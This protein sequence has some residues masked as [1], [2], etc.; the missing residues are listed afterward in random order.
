MFME[1]LSGS[2]GKEAIAKATNLLYSACYNYDDKSEIVFTEANMTCAVKAVGCGGPE[3]DLLLV[4]DLVR[5]HLGFHAWRYHGGSISFQSY[6]HTWLIYK[7]CYFI[8]R[9]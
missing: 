9:L 6:H 5:C 3:P 4:H 7:N 1:Y 2:D 8:P